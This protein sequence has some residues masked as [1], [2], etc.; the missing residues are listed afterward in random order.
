MK[1]SKFK[2]R[3]VAIYEY[4]YEK[5][6]VPRIRIKYRLNIMSTQRTIKYVIKNKC[7][8]SR[9]G[10]GEFNIMFWTSKIAFQKQDE[11]LA[12]KMRNAL[13]NT[14][15]N[16][17][18]CMPRTM[19][20]DRGYNEK[21]KMWWR[22]WSKH[23]QSKIVPEIIKRTGNHYV[24]GDALMTRPY[25]DLKSKRTSKRIFDSLKRIWDN[26]DI[27]IVEGEQTRLGVG[28]DLFS[29]ATSIKRILAPAINAFECYDKIVETIIKHH[30]KE[31]ILIA[32]GPTATVLAIDLAS[33]KRQA[34]DIGHID[35]EYEW[36]LTDAK[37]KSAISGKFTNEVEDGREVKDC[38]DEKYLSEIIDR[39]CCRSN[40]AH[41][42]RNHP[43]I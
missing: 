12:E 25:M 32:L 13:R 23:R 43:R 10:E 2:R 6:L 1:D 36:F 3:L 15:D 37:E 38:L 31:L 18:I 5:I 22:D 20:C 14:S 33:E 11:Q 7:S 39:V 9:Y 19:V 21:A 29:N 35:I 30:N 41:N 42:H 26:R 34:I 27:L 40:Y 4:M 17:L 24:F 8:V 28:N 16:I